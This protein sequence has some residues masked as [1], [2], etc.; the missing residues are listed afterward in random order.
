M[1]KID[2]S[3]AGIATLGRDE[4]A[5]MAHVAA[6]EMVVPPV[7]S[8]ETRARLFQEMQ[9]VGLDPNEYTV[10]EG[11]SINPITGMPEFG[12]LKKVFKS[13]KKVAKKV[14]PVVLP[15]VLPG[16]GNIIG[17]GLSSLGAALNIPATSGILDTFAKV[18]GG[19]GGL[20]GG[21]GGGGPQQGIGSVLSGMFGGPM[22]TP[23]INEAANA[24]N[25][26]G[27]IANFLGGMFGGGTGGGLGGGLGPLANLT[28]ARN[29]LRQNP[30]NSA[31]SLI[32]TGVASFGYTPE[33]IAALSNKDYGI[34]N[35][36][37]AL[38]QGQQYAN[39]NPENMPKST[40]ITMAEK[41]GQINPDRM[42]DDGP[43]DITPAFLEP[44]EF[45]I[46]RP[47]TRVLGARN[48]YKLMKE[49]EQMA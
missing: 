16:V 43:G 17:G 11:M 44:G 22:N 39:I 1:N 26:P 49:A 46:T 35:L 29:I 42:D 34:G 31:A 23:G 8:S 7:I 21:T 14:A 9:Q 32:P 12:F 48:L 47:A 18:R 37:P 30:D 2:N 13:V 3:G 25:T 28:I 4:D 40:P 36:Q 19:I 6:G 10:G 15:M 45:V 38:I 41:G 24:T 5:Y 20:F 27:G 33:M